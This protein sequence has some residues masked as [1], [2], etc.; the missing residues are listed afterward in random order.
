[1]PV[2]IVPRHQ[3]GEPAE[4]QLPVGKRCQ[5]ALS[6]LACADAILRTIACLNRMPGKMGKNGRQA[7]GTQPLAPP[8]PGGYKASY[9][10][11]A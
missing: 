4:R 11:L 3:I 1:M 2:K 9:L 7:P 6:F 8:Q 10:P 5:L